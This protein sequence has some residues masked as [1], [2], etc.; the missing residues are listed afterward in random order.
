[1]PLEVRL[2]RNRLKLDI[3][4]FRKRVLT[5]LLL[6]GLASCSLGPEDPNKFYRTTG[7]R[8]CPDTKIERV[9]PEADPGSGFI[10][11]VDLTMSKKCRD[12][13]L[14]NLRERQ[15]QINEG[16]DAPPAPGETM[17]VED[18]GRNLRF[19]YSG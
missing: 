15:S 19:T 18:R 6:Y 16:S 3:P 14:N 2:E 17:S 5:A 1:M 8:L 10:Y 11:I 9:N 12:A 13:F 4:V 7:I